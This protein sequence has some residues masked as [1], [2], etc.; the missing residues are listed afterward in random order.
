M[1]TII[2]TL[3]AIVNFAIA[4]LTKTGRV[5]CCSGCGKL[6]LGKAHYHADCWYDSEEHRLQEESDRHLLEEDTT[7]ELITAKQEELIALLRNKVALYEG[8]LTR[9]RERLS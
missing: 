9:T 4:L 1:N 8:L 2:T 7:A 5:S 3:I 6:F